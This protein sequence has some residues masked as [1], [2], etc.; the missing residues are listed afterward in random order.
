MFLLTAS[1][2]NRLAVTPGAATAA[3][4]SLLPMSLMHWRHAHSDGIPWSEAVLALHESSGL[5]HGD[6]C[7]AFG[8]MPARARL[9]NSTCHDHEL[10]AGPGLS[11]CSHTRQTLS[12]FLPHSTDVPRARRLLV[13]PG[14]AVTLRQLRGISLRKSIDLPKLPG[15]YLAEVYAHMKLGEA[16]PGDNGSRAGPNPLESRG[17]LHTS[18]MCQ[19]SDDWGPP[20]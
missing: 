7:S 8:L 19:C 15:S 16:E 4:A 17:R 20:A 14:A 18:M 1:S 11:W 10:P 9:C 12:L 3:W 6:T 5:V 13:A 2:P